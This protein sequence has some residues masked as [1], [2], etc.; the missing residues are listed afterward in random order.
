M[1]LLLRSISRLLIDLKFW[2]DNRLM[3]TPNSLV[4]R[5]FGRSLLTQARYAPG[6][7][8]DKSMFP[9]ALISS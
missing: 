7:T 2:I 1:S 3:R 6:V 4:P 9:P 5:L 8:A